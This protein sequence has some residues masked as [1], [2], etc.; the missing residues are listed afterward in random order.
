MNPRVPFCVSVPRKSTLRLAACAA[1]AFLLL[2]SRGLARWYNENIPS[3]ADLVMMDLRW[4]WW[5]SDTY[6]ASW[7]IRFNPGPNNVSFYG[8]FL[9]GSRHGRPR[10]CLSQGGVSHG[11]VSRRTAGGEGGTNALY[12]SPDRG[13][14]VTR[15]LNASGAALEA[16][17]HA[18]GIPGE[19]RF[20]DQ[21]QRGI[22]NWKGTVVKQV[23]N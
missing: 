23:E 18:A 4:P 12:F 20:I 5:P 9:G 8:G 10:L 3:G 6:Y 16:D 11:R 7:N 13:R 1:L 17:C 21:P 2:P 22:Y 14:S 19:V 15:I